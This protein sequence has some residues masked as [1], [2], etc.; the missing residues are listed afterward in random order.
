MRSLTVSEARTR[1]ASISVSSY[2]VDLD[3]T[4]GDLHFGSTT[5]IEFD[6]RDHQSTWFDVQPS[7]LLRVQLNGEAVESAELVDGRLH[8]ERLRDHNVLVVEA[9]MTYSHDGEGLHRSVDPED[10]QAYVYAMTFLAAA[11]RVFA[12]FD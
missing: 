9:L 4:R 11:P 2:D 12:C 1:A 6:S 10:K 8:L 7:E 5:V 3:L